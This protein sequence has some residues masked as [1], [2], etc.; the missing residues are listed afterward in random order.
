MASVRMSRKLRENIIRNGNNLFSKPA[1]RAATS[2]ADDYSD[3]MMTHIWQDYFEKYIKSLPDDWCINIE[4]ADGTLKGNYKG[5][6]KNI[7]H[8]YRFTKKYKIP[9]IS[10][11]ITWNDSLNLNKDY[12]LSQELFDEL[13]EYKGRIEKVE[14]EKK[15]FVDQLTYTLNKC[16]TL[17]QFL[18]VFPDGEKLVPIT[19]ME[20]YNDKTAKPKSIA[21]EERMEPEVAT[22]LSSILMRRKIS[23][24]IHK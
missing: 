19:T 8:H 1:Q 3:R 10:K 14:K 21:A 12:I 5:E 13:A 24:A 2:L 22:E 16:N 11:L 17:K 20:I 18:D 4:T 23:D 7:N 9:H 15:T 6:I